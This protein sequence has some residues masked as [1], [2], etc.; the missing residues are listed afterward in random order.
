MVNFHITTTSDSSSAH[1]VPKE[2][3][4]HRTV[5]TLLQTVALLHRPYEGSQFG[6]QKLV[7]L[8]NVE[9][10]TGKYYLLTC[11]PLSD[12]CDSQAPSQIY[13]AF[14]ERG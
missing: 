3:S 8:G 13:R 9:V 10:A 14:T 4:Y 11:F 7:G 5:E 12:Q 6:I 2:G 1:L